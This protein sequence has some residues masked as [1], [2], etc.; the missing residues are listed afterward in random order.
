MTT[1]SAE[2]NA[3]VRLNDDALEPVNGGAGSAFAGIESMMD[4][5]KRGIGNGATQVRYH[6]ESQT[7]GGNTK[8]VT[9]SHFRR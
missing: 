3:P 8:T 9:Q 6:Q 2:Q 4:N 7:V 1:K 5:I